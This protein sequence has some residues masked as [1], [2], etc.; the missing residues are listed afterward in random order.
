MAVVLFH[1]IISSNIT[2]GGRETAT[3]LGTGDVPALTFGTNT[4]A[5]T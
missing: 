1:F 3:I 4:C 2:H 5:I